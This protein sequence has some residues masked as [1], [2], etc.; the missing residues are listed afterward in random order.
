MRYPHLFALAASLALLSTGATAAVFTVDALANSSTGGSGLATISLTSGDLFTVTAD[1]NDLWSIGQLPRYSDA[2]GLVAP[3]FATAADDSGQP[4]GTLIGNLFPLWNQAG[5]LAPY[6]SLVGEI[7]G[8]YQLLGANFSGAAWNTGVL[9]L[10]AWDENN[11]DNF[12]TISANVSIPPGPGVP[13]PATWA[14][15]IL[16]LGGIG[17]ALRNRRRP[18]LAKA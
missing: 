1:T 4:I 14:M 15:T 3:R 9:R 12:G 11:G 18:G 2:N 16:G 13:E 17:A 10:Y 5:L 8:V 6:A 7:G